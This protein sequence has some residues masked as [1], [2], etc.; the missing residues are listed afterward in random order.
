MTTLD[1]NQA[2]ALQAMDQAIQQ[3]FAHHQAGEL[4]EAE[5]IYR[6]VLQT[7]PN[8]PDVN[9]NLGV[10]AVQVG[11]PAA[12][13]PHF[14]AALEA[15]PL[16]GQYWLSYIDTL[17]RT[18]QSAI[19]REVLEQGR[20]HGLNSEAIEALEL[21]LK[22]NAV[23]EPSQQEAEALVALFTDKR[24][25]EASALARAMTERFP[26]YGLGWKILGAVFRQAGQDAEALTF[27]QTAAKLSP[28]DV[29]LH[30]NLGRVLHKLG[31]LP[32][33]AASY[34]QALQ[35]KPDYA[36]A[37]YNLGVTLQM[38]GQFTEAEASYRRAIRYRPDYAEAHS[39]LGS[40]LQSLKQYADA[41]ASY[42]QATQINPEYAGAHSNLGVILHQLGQPATAAASYQRAIEIR[43]DYAE[44]HYNLG[45]ALIDLGQFDEAVA[46]Y[47]QA[48]SIDPDF[49]EAHYNLGKALKNLGLFNAAI[50]SYRQA[51]ALKPDYID[52]HD[53]LLLTLNYLDHQASSHGLA[54][55][56]QFGLVIANKVKTRF[57]AWQCQAQPKRLRVG[58]VSGDLRNH[59]VGY[60]LEGLLAHID[61]AR[62]ELIAY[63]TNPIED[64]LS[65]RI[66]PCFSAWRHLFEQTDTD[67]A[68]LIHAD[69]VHVLL[70]LSGHTR[71]NRLPVFAWKPAPVQASWLG[72]FATTGVSEMDYLLADEVSVPPERQDQFTETIRYLP[73][74]R[75]CF[76]PP[77]LSVAVTPLPALSTGRIT[78]A[79]FQDFPKVGDEVLVLWGKI[80]AAVPKARLRLQCKL[81]GN[82]TQ[83]ERMFQRLQVHG[84]DRARV[85][86]LGAVPR[87]AY[88][89]AHAKVDVILDTFPYPGGTTTCEALWMGVPTL[90]LAGDTLLS[91][92]GASLIRA[93]GL[94]EWVADSREDYI[95]KAV[96]FSNDLPGLAALRASLRQRVLASPLFDAPRFARNFEAA[97]WS[98]SG[99]ASP[100][101]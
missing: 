28:G 46:S 82:Q 25:A 18:G 19:A 60:F 24:Y 31:R 35:A 90:T 59:V 47:Q 20:Q 51:L 69:G 41:E 7:Q 42:R 54:Q 75:L 71:H 94:G 33:A 96:A 1:L 36:E 98:M 88:L 21:E 6:S 66:R 65:A 43:P 85:E 14:K 16:P 79:C 29:G 101:S 87:E 38:Q 17:I 67:A 70:D 2:S 15:N 84:I 48:L 95:A 27:L 80:F 5:Q 4:R 97:L 22:K 23:N 45:K 92:Q 68:A 9:H 13:L 11:Q 100:E 81:L 62:I 55:A 64:D 32:E 52:A 61:P 39:N 83:V 89:A 78:F 12:G 56:R 86:I 10:I 93:A 26:L 53:N 72:Y 76:T 40:T 49:S 73:D 8:H 30:N 77:R 99:Y 91:R 58:L 34:R 37:C 57:T 44:A 74:A 3:A 63:A 50:A